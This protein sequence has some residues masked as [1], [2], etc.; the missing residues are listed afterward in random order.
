MGDEA[1]ALREIYDWD[2]DYEERD[3][4][5]VEILEQRYVVVEMAKVGTMIRCPVCNKLIK[6]KSY[7]HKFCSNRG[8]GNCKDRYWNSVDEIRRARA[9]RFNS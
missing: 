1:D 5:Y 8:R 3:F 4:H 9:V 2:I 7:Q 6:K